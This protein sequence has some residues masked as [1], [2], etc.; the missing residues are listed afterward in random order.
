MKIAW[1]FPGQGSQQV[2]M[3]RELAEQS[4]AAR[5]VFDAADRALAAAGAGEPSLSRLCFEGPE[6]QLTL[7]INTQPAL[8]TTSAALVAALREAHP[9]L[10]GGAGALPEP[11]IALGHSLGEYSA[12]V[13]S[14]ALSSRTR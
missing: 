4:A 14:G 3:G 5:A 6:D 12:L 11:A 8:V 1:L 2:G 13:A 9:A 7:T 10:A